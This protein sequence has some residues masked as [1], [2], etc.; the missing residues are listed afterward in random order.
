MHDTLKVIVGLALFFALV[1]LPFWLGAVRSAPAPAPDLT[2][3]DT[4]CVEPV[5]YMRANH[6][7]LLD[8]WRNSVVRDGDRV[9]VNSAGKSFQKSLTKTCLNCHAQKEKFCDQCHQSVAVEPYCFS[10]HLAPGQ[11][12][13]LTSGSRLT[14]A[15]FSTPM[16]GRQ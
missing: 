5:A 15:D 10:C 8:Q 11:S 2:A 12:L 4:Q 7:K 13:V 6:M 1:T 9:Y 16:D 14:V 3:K